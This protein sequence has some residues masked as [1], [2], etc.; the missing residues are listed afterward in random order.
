M[1]ATVVSMRLRILFVTLQSTNTYPAWRSAACLALASDAG[2]IECRSLSTSV[3]EREGKKI[4]EREEE[5][6][7]TRGVHLSERG[8]LLSGQKCVWHVGSAKQFWKSHGQF[9]K[10]S[11]TFPT[12]TFL[13]PTPHNS[14]SESHN[15]TKHTLN[16][17]TIF[18]LFI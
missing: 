9:N 6:G 13:R 16:Y 12:Y 15:S 3:R 7:L 5:D 14:F 1:K 4:G 10:Q 17:L 2:G 18:S 8:R 11:S